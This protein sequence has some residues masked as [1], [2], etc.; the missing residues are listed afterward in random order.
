MFKLPSSLNFEYQSSSSKYKLDINM[1]YH[2]DETQ[3]CYPKRRPDNLKV[4]DKINI[5]FRE[6]SF[7]WV[8]YGIRFWKVQK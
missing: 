1:S 2:R 4:G 7:L 3:I 5:V 8:M 6:G